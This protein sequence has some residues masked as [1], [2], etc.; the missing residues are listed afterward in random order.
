LNINK[1]KYNFAGGF[2][3]IFLSKKE[4]EAND[5]YAVKVLIADKRDR[6]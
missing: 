6:P 4:G 2:G 1:A 5:D 3:L